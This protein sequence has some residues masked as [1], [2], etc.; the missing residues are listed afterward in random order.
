[1]KIRFTSTG[2]CR[3]VCVSLLAL[4]LS[5]VSAA[6]NPD[7]FNA[8]NEHK[9][10]SSK[11]TDFARI[12]DA[13]RYLCENKSRVCSPK[14]GGFDSKGVL[15]VEGR[16]ETAQYKR[17][18]G[19]TVEGLS[20]QRNY[21]RVIRQMNGR[22]VGEMDG[23]SVDRGW[24]KQVF[25]IEQGSV[26]KWVL[27][28]TNS[29]SNSV[30]VSVLTIAAAPEILSAAAMKNEIDGKGYVTL[31]VNF[32]TNKALIRPE[33]KPTLDQ[34]VVLLKQSSGL[35]LSVEGHTDNVGDAA[36]NRRL[37]QERAESIVAYLTKAGIA[38]SRLQ[39]KGFGMGV[40]IADNRAEEGRAKNRRV[41]LVKIQ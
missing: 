34:V 16:L 20:L 27:V 40:P 8:P 4:S 22:L 3:S 28:D 5:H 41:E 7:G 24:M 15:N 39:A 38:S 32:E 35:K 13:N 1:M 17:I 36:A 14:D 19:K 26:K 9:I 6:E 2:F 30:N 10:H 25:L 12:D 23:H 37:S 11:R 18:D 21:E 31:N 33:D 29:D